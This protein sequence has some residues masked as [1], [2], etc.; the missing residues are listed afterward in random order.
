MLDFL[1]GRWTIGVIDA[2]E[3]ESELESHLSGRNVADESLSLS[4]L[5]TRSS[6][7]VIFMS[8]RIL[9]AYNT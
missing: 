2:S 6:S 9:Y 5:L 7:D 8:S 3:S 1:F 4:L